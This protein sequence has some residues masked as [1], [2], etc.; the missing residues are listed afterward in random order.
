MAKT[1]KKSRSGK[2]NVVVAYLRDTRAELRKV[3]WPTRQEAWNLTKV[4][5]AVTIAMALLLAVL[6]YLFALELQG[7][8]A[9]DPLA[10]VVLG[11]VAVAG[12]IAYVLLRRQTT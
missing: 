11:V 1:E 5:M 4:V 10:Y 2:P 3:H 7:L 12:V 8:I 9:Q 6:D